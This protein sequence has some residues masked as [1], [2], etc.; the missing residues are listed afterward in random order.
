MGFPLSGR[1]HRFGW[2]G[3]DLFFVLSGYLIGGQLLSPARPRSPHPLRP[4]LRPARA[5]HPARLPRHPRHLFAVTRLARIPGDV[6][7]LEIL[8]LRPKHRAPRRDRFFARLVARDRRP[9]LSPAAAHPSLAG[10]HPSRRFRR[11]VRHRDLRGR[12]SAGSSPGNTWRKPAS[13]GAAS[14]PGSTTLPG[15]GSIRSS[16]ASP[17]LRSRNSGRTGGSG[18][19]L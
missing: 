7:R 13:T 10:P 14:R 18:Y 1:I 19:S 15:P 3:V 2:I 4:L 6:S 9:I 8:P 11:P 5:P 16:S 12:R 17:W